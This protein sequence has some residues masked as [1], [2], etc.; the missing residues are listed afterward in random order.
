MLLLVPCFTSWFYSLR[1]V[2]MIYVLVMLHLTEKQY[3]NTDA[4]CVQVLLG[5]NLVLEN[6]A[7]G[8]V[9]DYLFTNIIKY[10]DAMKAV[11]T[12]TCLITLITFYKLRFRLCHDTLVVLYFHFVCQHIYFGIVIMPVLD[13]N[14]SV[15]FLYVIHTS[16]YLNYNCTLISLYFICTICCYHFVNSYMY[17]EIPLPEKFR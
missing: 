17:N 15:K 6:T 4:F 9:L 10:L 2:P 12:Q 11:C 5:S 16:I 7:V 1:Y 3:M 13:T 8:W 14:I